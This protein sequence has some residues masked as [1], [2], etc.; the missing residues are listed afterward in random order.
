MID[1]IML[2]LKFFFKLIDKQQDLDFPSL[3]QFDNKNEQ[4]DD[5]IGRNSSKDISMSRISGLNRRQLC[6]TNSV[7]SERLP[8]YGVDTPH[9]KDLGNVCVKYIILLISKL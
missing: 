6:H 7:I 8:L 2:K 3:Q 1:V 4:K 5:K 9:E